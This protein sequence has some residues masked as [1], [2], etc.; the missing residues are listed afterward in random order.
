MADRSIFHFQSQKGSARKRLP[1]IVSG[2]FASRSNA[3]LRI[4]SHLRMPS[5]L[6]ELLVSRGLYLRRRPRTVLRGSPATCVLK[7][8]RCSPRP[9]CSSSSPL[10]PRP[11]SRSRSAFP[12]S[13]G[14]ATLITTVKFLGD[15][16]PFQRAVR[17]ASKSLRCLPR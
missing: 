15:E 4:V 8:L 14:K 10:A 7:L 5:R 13:R 2:W 17:C 3:R 1:S 9:R 12:R 6:R 11:R 16:S